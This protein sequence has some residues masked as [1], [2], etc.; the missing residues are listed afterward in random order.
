MGDRVIRLQYL[1]A[2]IKKISPCSLTSGKVQWV[3]RWTEDHRVV[4]GVVS[5]PQGDVYGTPFAQ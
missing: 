4:Q 1:F 3:R 5:S 2:I